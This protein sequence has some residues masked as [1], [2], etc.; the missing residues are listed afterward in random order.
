M[1]SS[2]EIKPRGAEARPP[3]VMPRFKRGI[4]VSQRPLVGTT[5]VSGMLDRPIKSGDDT[6]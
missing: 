3:A 6:G 5:A 4:Q 2:G 1:Q